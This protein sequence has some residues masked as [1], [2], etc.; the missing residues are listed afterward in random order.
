MGRKGS[1]RSAQCEN[2]KLIPLRGELRRA[3]TQ[4][5]E[6]LGRNKARMRTHVPAL[7]QQESSI[8]MKEGYPEGK[9]SAET[10]LVIGAALL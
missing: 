1:W 6:E 7:E 9:K 3:A 10:C 4:E 5:D 2:P 8:T